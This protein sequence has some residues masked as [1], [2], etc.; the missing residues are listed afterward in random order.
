MTH[1]ASSRDQKLQD[2]LVA[3][4]EAA[5]KGQ[6]PDPQELLQRHP[7]FAAELADFLANRA[8][9]D[10]LTAPLRA[11]AQAA[12]KEAAASRTLATGSA[13][14]P[15]P[16][17]KVRYF[18]DYELLE[19]IARGGMGVV[20]KARQVSLSRLV[21]LK[22]ILAG[23]LASAADVQRFRAEAEA[24]AGLDHPHIVPIYEVGEHE[25]QHY[26][27]MKLV[28]G[29]SLTS[30]VAE[31][32][33]QPRTAARL[34][35]QVALA[36]HYAHQ[37]GILHRDLKPANILLDGSGLPHVTDFGLAKRVEGG[38]DLTR[39]GAVVG[40]PS[41]MPPE[42]ARGESVLTTA[43]DVYSLG[44]VLYELLTGKPP[45]RA[46]TPV[47]TLLQVMEREPVR[48]RSLNPRLDRDLETICLKCLEK[49]PQ[50]RYGSAE[51]LAEDLRRFLAHE[52]IAARPA[53]V[54]DRLAKWTR[55]RPAIAAL[56]LALLV[57]LVGLL[58][59]ATWSYV[60]I[61]RALADV[62]EQR[63]AAVEAGAREAQQR[64]AA[65]H[66][67]DAAVAETYR[68]LLSETRAL[69]LAHPPGWRS[70]ALQQIRRLMQLETAR[71]VAELRSEAI[72]CIG[73]FDVF[74]AAYP[75]GGEVWSLD[76]SP[77]GTMLA[78]AS[79]DGSVRLWDLASGRDLRVLRDSGVDTA[80][81]HQPKAPLPAVRFRPGGD[82]LAY[83]TWGQGIGFLEWRNKEVAF[84]K[85]GRQAPARYLAFDGSGRL[86]AVSWGDGRVG[87]YDA[88]TGATA[89]E[90]ET[91]VGK[92][93]HL[94]VALSPDGKLL[95]AMGPDHSVQL[96]AVADDKPP[97]SLGKHR[98][99]VRGLCF[100]GAGD[101]LA[102]ASADHTVKLWTTAGQAEE[103]LTLVGHSA[104]V[105]CVAFSPD[106]SLLA[107]GSD[108][109]TVRLWEAR[110]GEVLR[111]LPG[112]GNLLSV[113]FSPDGNR[114]AASDNVTIYQLAR[115]QGRQQLAGHSYGVAG[116]VFHP[117]KPLLATAA[118]DR[119]LIFWDV[120]TG[121]PL[122]RARS[123]RSNPIQA[124]AAAPDGSLLATGVGSYTN[125]SGRD[126]A[127]DLWDWDTGAL[128]RQLKGPQADITTLAFDPS[129]KR[130]ASGTSDGTWFVWDLTTDEIV[131]RGKAST[132]A[133]RE[134]LFLNHGAQLL[135]GKSE[136]RIEVR[137]LAS[138]KTVREVEVPGGL[139]SLAAAADG[140]CLVAG[141]GDGTLRLLTLPGLEEKARLTAGPGP[142]QALAYSPD[143]RLVACSS[144]DRQVTLWDARSQQRLFTLPQ[145]SPVHQLSFDAASQRLAIC[146]AAE[147]VTLWNFAQV[148]PELD[149]VGL[150]WQKP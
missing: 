29:P 139:S 37:R 30:Q 54:V 58:G 18:G 127:I 122:R 90:V 43:V 150:G 148:Q 79:Y 72:A 91:K 102:S 108:D 56:T 88:G 57:S 92:Y 44:A 109:R 107:T 124:I 20:F 115:G 149:A 73:E 35:S 142:I 86:M 126:F 65:E 89:R 128:R 117:R 47:E 34:V 123:E 16:G 64:G 77:D 59:L 3:Y 63:L 22:M 27:S 103:P 13:D 87:V 112:R 50:R 1:E 98:A 121:Q 67:R 38:T 97:V 40:T 49:E 145:N 130:L 105:N 45:F 135:I 113:A 60:R 23:Q 136:G 61:S 42:Q 71:N 84:P 106:G 80:Q 12:A 10:R 19:E 78:I 120:N 46:D 118:W 5:E 24:A 41:Y 100:S 69:R 68:A 132:G 62:E 114:L 140:S 95:A 36:V 52:P 33:R 39:S 7:E 143:G 138:G 11:V 99:V 28:E 116:S 74:A 14:S 111:V 125:A 15:R 94:P 75:L 32:A 110:T 53:G 6:P 31:L 137:D 48:P 101:R 83:T 96:Y 66:A 141:G 133:I 55:R 4:L 21:A 76:F 70:E 119:Q 82:W 2:V 131:Q 93:F 144:A 85:L 147:L 104:R 51:A 146:G 17:E 26:F 134:V 81:L 129:S 9:L 25:G 8:Q